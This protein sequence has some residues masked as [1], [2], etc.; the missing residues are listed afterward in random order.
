MPAS[1]R[2]SD[3]DDD[4]Q[5]HPS[6]SPLTLLLLCV[7]LRGR[8]DRRADATEQRPRESRRPDLE[9]GVV[10]GQQRHDQRHSTASGRAPLTIDSLVLEDSD[11]AWLAARGVAVDW[12]PLALL[13][14]TFEAS[15][16]H[17]DRIELARL[18]E[19]AVRERAR[20]GGLPVSLD[21]R[22]DRP[23]RDRARA[24][25]WPARWRRSRREGLARGRCRRRWR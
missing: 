7:A 16:V 24:A 5:A 1:A 2:R 23:A 25:R 21:D 17:A 8:R 18:A 11:G 3:A 10:A 13:S 19:G 22:P 12:S 20:G 4:P 9:H 15:L 14:S 6:H